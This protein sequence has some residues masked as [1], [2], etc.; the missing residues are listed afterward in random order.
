MLNRTMSVIALALVVAIGFPPAAAYA[1]GSYRSR[2]E[3]Y[4][5]AR[6]QQARTTFLAMQK[7]GWGYKT[8]AQKNR[9]YAALRVA[10]GESGMNPVNDR[11][12]SCSGLF[13]IQGGKKA[14]GKWTARELSN[15]R[16]LAK[17]T[18]GEDR[19]LFG[20]LR[21]GGKGY[22]TKHVVYYKPRVGEYKIF[23]PVFNAEIALR[24]HTARGWKPWTVARK[25]GYR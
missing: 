12:K 18:L 6:P 3:Q 8:A 2:I 22:Y 20:P 19:R 13:Q 25:L 9:A 11:N 7:A 4:V 5:K 17:Y 23:N 15:P 14:Y 24:M 10:A 21:S 16:V 1:A